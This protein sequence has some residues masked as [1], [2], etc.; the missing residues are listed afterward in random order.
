MIDVAVITKV[1]AGASLLGAYATFADVDFRGTIT[2][3]SLLVGLLIAT[4]AGFATIRSRVSSIWREEAN[5]WREK[6]E[7]QER[8]LADKNAEMA[9]FAHDQ[10]ERRHELKS[11]LAGVAAKLKVEEA[12][13]DLGV[14]LERMQDFHNEAMA[15]MSARSVAA[16]GE[17]GARLDQQLRLLEEI[18]DALKGGTR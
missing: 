14:L 18:R 10:Q 9:E 5:G 16:V 15:A 3:G 17:V 6:A 11:E 7:R 2:L 1:V 4:V 13:H 8:E 12:K